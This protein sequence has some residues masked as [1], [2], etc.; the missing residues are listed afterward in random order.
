MVTPQRGKQSLFECANMVDFEAIKI[1]VHTGID[2]DNFEI[3]WNDTN[4]DTGEL[5]L[6]P[7]DIEAKITTGTNGEIYYLIYMIAS[8]RSEINTGGAMNYLIR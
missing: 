7:G 2:I 5:L 8:F 1:T 4:S 6:K 3:G